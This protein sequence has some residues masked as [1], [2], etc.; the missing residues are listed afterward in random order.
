MERYHKEMK[1]LISVNLSKRAAPFPLAVSDRPPLTLP[2]TQ[3]VL[4]HAFCFITCP[5]STHSLIGAQTRTA[6]RAHITLIDWSEEQACAEDE[7]ILR[8]NSVQLLPS[9]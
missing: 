6:Y 3:A 7:N 2:R 4:R 1:R 9:K 8:C 5:S